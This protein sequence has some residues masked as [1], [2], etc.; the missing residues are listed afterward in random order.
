MI[1]IS[2]VHSNLEALSAVLEQVGDEDVYCLGDVVGYGADPNGVIELLKRRRV[3]C[4]E[5]NHDR[6]A[7]TGVPSGFSRGAAMA[8]LW[9]HA[10]LNGSSL[11]FLKGLEPELQFAVGSKRVYLTHG[12]PDDR[13]WE[14]VDPTTHAG[15]FDHYLAKVQAD[16]IGLGHTHIPYLWKNPRG[17]VFNPGSIGQPRN[18]DRRASFAEME[19]FADEELSVSLRNVEYNYEVAAAKIREAGL[20]GQLAERLYLGR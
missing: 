18:G 12:S 4:I 13:L 2:D 17:T 20:P 15:L 1:F 8:A 3:C 7:V 6:A 19:L 11:E 9:T 14:Y 16:V 5:G 10:H